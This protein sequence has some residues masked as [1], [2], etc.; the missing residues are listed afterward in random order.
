M[1]A[2][3]SSLAAF[4]SPAAL[5]LRRVYSDRISKEKKKFIK[6]HTVKAKLSNNVVG[7]VNQR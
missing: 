1:K 2:K 3:M 4:V 7:N 5:T 6:N